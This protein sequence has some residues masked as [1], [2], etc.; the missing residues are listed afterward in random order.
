MT[1]KIAVSAETPHARLPALAGRR[2][3]PA[4]LA[5]LARDYGAT[6]GS[7]WWPAP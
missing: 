2:A 6:A 5:T 4:A 3:A 1:Q 7:A